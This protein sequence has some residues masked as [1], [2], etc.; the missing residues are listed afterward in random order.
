MILSEHNIILKV[1]KI[2]YILY[3]DYMNASFLNNLLKFNNVSFVWNFSEG[4]LKWIW[5]ILDENNLNYIFL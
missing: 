2:L 1:Y 5:N 3:K 4:K